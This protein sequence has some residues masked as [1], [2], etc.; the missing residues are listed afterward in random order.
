MSWRYIGERALSANT[1]RIVIQTER[2]SIAAR[3][4]EAL[5]TSPD[6]ETLSD[7]IRSIAFT[8]DSNGDDSGAAGFLQVEVEE[9]D[10]ISGCTSEMG[11]RGDR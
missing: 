4:R 1:E 11:N 7:A 2:E 8:L 9:T 10:F 5:E 3:L 6:M